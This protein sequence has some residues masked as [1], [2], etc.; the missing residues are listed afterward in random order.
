[1]LGGAQH[2]AGSDRELSFSCT[3]ASA[4]PHLPPPQEQHSC[5]V[6]P[7]VPSTQDTEGRS[8]QDFVESS[9]NCPAS[10]NA[11][12][13]LLHEACAHT[14][15]SD[16]PCLVHALPPGHAYPRMSQRPSHRAH[17]R[18]PFFTA[19]HTYLGLRPSPGLLGQNTAGP[20]LGCAAFPCL[21]C[22][23]ALPPPG[24]ALG[25]WTAVSDGVWSSSLCWAPATCSLSIASRGLPRAEVVCLSSPR[26]AVYASASD[27]AGAAW[28]AS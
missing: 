1:M 7:S 21:R 4:A 27:P 2:R 11:L 26:G 19:S 3:S 13:L 8:W 10:P 18:S 14:Y 20:Y 23:V 22:R 9:G 17:S 25:V 15:P 24:L 28:L 5:V 16:A 12:T 6:G